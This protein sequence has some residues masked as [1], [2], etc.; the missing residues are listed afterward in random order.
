MV[1]IV[2]P[3]FKSKNIGDQVCQSLEDLDPLK[4]SSSRIEVVVV[5]HAQL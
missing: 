4:V 3:E 1:E 2:D 5:T